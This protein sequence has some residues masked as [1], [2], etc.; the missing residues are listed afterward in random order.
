MPLPLTL[1]K[2]QSAKS[3]DNTRVLLPAYH[4]QRVH[5][6]TMHMNNDRVTTGMKN[7]RGD[8]KSNLLIARSQKFSFK[9]N[10]PRRRGLIK[11]CRKLITDHRRVN[12]RRA[13]L[14]VGIFNIFIKHRAR[15]LSPIRSR[16]VRTYENTLDIR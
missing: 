7:A 3:S 9:H 16:Y 2:Y 1:D 8:K 13:Y 4:R 10:T 14:L 12:S 11:F 15:S 5:R 6:T